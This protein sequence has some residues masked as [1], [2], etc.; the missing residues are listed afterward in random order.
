MN[1]IFLDIDGVLNCELHYRSKQF[2]DYRDAKKQ[3]RKDVKADRIDR[4]EYYKS[5]L[6]TERM[7]WLNDL[8]ADTDSVV[9]I[10][11]TWRHGKTPEQLQ[12]ILSNSGATFKVIDKTKHF[13]N[14]RGPEIYQWIQDNSH[15]RFGILPSDFKSYVIID[16]DSD[17]LIWQLPH[18]FQTDCYSGLT[19]NIC[20]RI[21]RFFKSL[22]RE[23][24]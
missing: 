17:M 14:L 11:S 5:Q 13:G 16:D 1:V 4:D 21:R 6:C 23:K 20:Y 2:T 18:F 24:L 19:P 3:L 8:C 9:V 15:P 7:G 22:S 10:S 12:E